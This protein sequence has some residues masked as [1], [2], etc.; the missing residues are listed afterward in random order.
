MHKHM[1]KSNSLSNMIFY[2]YFFSQ[3]KC[4]NLTNIENIKMNGLSLKTYQK[5]IADQNEVFRT[6]F[7]FR[8]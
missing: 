8:M 1:L 2:D 6:N 5:Q 7:I 3:S 4:Q